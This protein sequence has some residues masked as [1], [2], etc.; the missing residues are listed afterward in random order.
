MLKCGYVICKEVTSGCLSKEGPVIYHVEMDN[1]RVRKC[2]T[3]QLRLRTI[4]ADTQ[5]SLNS[6]TLPLT[7]TNASSLAIPDS[8]LAEPSTE[9]DSLVVEPS[10][11]TTTPN[12]EQLPEPSPN[13]SSAEPSVIQPNSDNPHRH[14]TRVLKPVDRYI[15]KW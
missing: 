8:T 11:E 4:Q 15:P 3:D 12:T 13:S 2:H 1:G 5:D 6:P 9:S 14:S 10:P 7:G